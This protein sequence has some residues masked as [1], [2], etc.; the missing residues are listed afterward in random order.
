MRTA[1]TIRR[2][3][4]LK[5]QRMEAYRYWQNRTAAER[6]RA[7]DEVV[8][9]AYLAKGIDLNLRPSNRNLVRVVRRNW[10]AA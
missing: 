2:V 10:K 8:R 7:I 9:E 1:R 6:M 3:T 5:A 4:D